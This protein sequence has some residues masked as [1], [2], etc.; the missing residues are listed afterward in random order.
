[1][2]LVDINVKGGFWALRAVIGHMR[3]Q[4]TGGAIINMASMSDL[5]GHPNRGIYCA[6]KGAL[7]NMTRAVA[8]EVAPEKIRV[9]CV[10]PGVIDTPMFGPESE[11]RS[12]FVK[13]ATADN[14]IPR[15]GTAD[16]V[17]QGILFVIQNDFVTGTTIDVD[18]GWL[19]T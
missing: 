6:G 16:E 4:G 1:M 7:V 14:L 13:S 5:V 10:C 17:A 11:K 19:L 12:D 2:N 3:K 9:N 8:M 18:G 15:G